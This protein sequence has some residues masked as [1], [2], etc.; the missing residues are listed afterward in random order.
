MIPALMIEMSQ[1]SCGVMRSLPARDD[2]DG[3]AH[4]ARELAR[5]ARDALAQL[6]VD[7]RLHG[8]ASR[9]RP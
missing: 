4:L 3:A 6:A 8:H 1:G 5:D 2:V 9:R 7:A